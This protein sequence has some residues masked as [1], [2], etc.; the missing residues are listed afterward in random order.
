MET[1]F[2]FVAFRYQLMYIQL[3]GHC[4]LIAPKNDSTVPAVKHTTIQ[5]Q[6]Q[7]SMERQPIDSRPCYAGK[8]Q[9]APFKCF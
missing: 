2:G 5:K 3:R 6:W 8:S 1:L 9:W 7:P 4:R